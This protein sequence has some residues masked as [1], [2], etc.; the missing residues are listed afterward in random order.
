MDVD[1]SVSQELWPGLMLDIV[2]PKYLE[3]KQRRKDI[4]LAKHNV[5][6]YSEC[7]EEESRKMRRLMLSMEFLSTKYNTCLSEGRRSHYEERDVRRFCK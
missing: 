3:S 7:L 4:C 1:R 6:D 5:S 2:Q